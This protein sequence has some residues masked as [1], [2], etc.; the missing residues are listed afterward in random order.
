MEMVAPLRTAAVM[1]IVGKTSD[2]A[3]PRKAHTFVRSAGE[4]RW[5]AARGTREHHDLR[6]LKLA[7]DVLRR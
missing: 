3:M 6:S 5:R 2:T 7:G 4:A 1:P